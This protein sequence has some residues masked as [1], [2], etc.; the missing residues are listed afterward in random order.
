[1]LEYEKNERGDITV[2]SLKGNLDAL[3]APSLKKE[4]EGLLA[5]RR[6]FV[7]FDLSNLELIDSSGVG[8]I[9]SLF[10]RV[11]TLHGDVKIAQLT[12]QPAEIFKLLRLD[13]AFEIFDTID[14]AVSKFEA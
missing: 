1:M 10:K 8:A 11:R 5:A 4:I 2:F 6:I 12:G 13:R 9:V 3:T 14:G 7:V